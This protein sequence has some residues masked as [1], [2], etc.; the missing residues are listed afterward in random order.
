MVEDGA[1]IGGNATIMPNV[2][3]GRKAVVSAGALVD[4]DVRPEVVVVGS[5]A[6]PWMTREEYDKKQ[7]EWI[8]KYGGEQT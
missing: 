8:Q 7:R 4:E 1:V 6:R 3:I 2:K 5:P